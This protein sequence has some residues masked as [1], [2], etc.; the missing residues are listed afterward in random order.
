MAG[1]VQRTHSKF[2]S[3]LSLRRATISRTPQRNRRTISIHALLAESDLCGAASMCAAVSFLS[4]LSLRR[5]THVNISAPKTAKFLSTLSLRRATGVHGRTARRFR[6]F[7]PRSPCGERPYSCKP[8]EGRE[9]ISIHALLAES[10]VRAGAVCAAIRYFYPRSPCGERP[11][12]GG[13][14]LLNVI[15]L[16]TLS[17][18]RATLRVHLQAI[19]KHIS[20]HALLAESDRGRE[21]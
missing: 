7:Y 18:R 4:T 13:L 20:I 11:I 15:F 9:R 16:S 5:A 10:D 1:N 14:K 12:A 6:H 2:L 3:T 17:L 21:S 8:Q 19:S